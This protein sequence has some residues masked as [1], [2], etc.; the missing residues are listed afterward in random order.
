M[1]C[2]RARDICTEPVYAVMRYAGSTRSR[3]ANHTHGIHG[4][5]RGREVV[6]DACSATS[7]AAARRGGA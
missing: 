7:H 5:R 3:L 1:N 2:R 6:R 4:R